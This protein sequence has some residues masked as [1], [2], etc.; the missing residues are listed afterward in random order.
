MN[1]QERPAAAKPQSNTVAPRQLPQHFEALRQGKA[2]FDLGRYAEAL[3]CFNLFETHNPGIAPLYQTRGLCLQRLGRFD[4]AQADFERSIALSP[5]EAETHKNLG[6]LHSRL[7]R[8]E[9]AFAS[10]DRALA[11]R[12]NFPAA[13]TEKARALWSLHRLDEAFAA[14]HKSL[15]LEPGNA[16]TIWNLAVLQMLTGDFERGLAGREARWKASLGLVDRGFSAPLWLGDQPIADKTILLHADEGLGDSIQL[17]RYAPMLAALGARVILEVSTPL[18][19]LLGGTTGV[20]ACIGRSS[21]PSLAFDL[22]C[23]LGSLPLA[24]TTRP[25]TIPFADG[26]LPAPAAER[27]AAWEDRLG[28]HD[29]F[30]VGLVWSG[31]PAHNNDHNRS[32]PLRTLAPLL[33]CDVQFVSLQKGARDQDRAFLDGHPDIVDL[34]E[35]L[36]DFSDTAALVACLDL[37]ISV[38]TSVAHLAGAM[39]APVWTMLPF[40]PDWRWL[41]GRDDSPWYSSMRLFRQP[42]R[43]DWVSVVDAVRRALDG[44]VCEWQSGAQQLQSKTP[45]AKPQ[46]AVISN[47]LGHMFRQRGRAD[48]AVLHFRRALELHP[49]DLDA[50]NCCGALLFNLGRYAE[51]LECFDVAEKLDPGSAALYQMRGACLQE[52]NRFEEAEADY[53]KSIALDPSQAETYNNFGLLHARLGRHEQA[54]AHFDRSLELRPDFSAVLNNKA[55]ALLNLQLLD[56]AVATFHRSLTVDPGNAPATFNL[57]TIQLLTGDLER[58]FAGREARW[59]LPVGLPERG[60]SQPLWR[61]DQPIAGKTLLLHSEE[62][63]G[64]A[65]Q[66]ARYA[67]M[68][69]A[70]GARVILE[71]Q[72]PIRQLL[73]EVSGVAD[74][75]D[76]PSATS[77]AFDLH[78]PLG[79]LPSAFGTRLDTIPFAESYIPAPPPERMAAWEDRLGP[80]DRFRVGLVWS[81]NPGHKNDHNRSMPLRT[82]APLLDCDVQFVS[83]QKSA[84]DEDLAFLRECSDIIDLSD[85]LT[86]MSDT[87]ALVACLDLVI[88]V[89]TSVAHLAGAL[90]APVWTMLPFNPDWRWLL[91]RDD[92]PWYSS[93]RLFRQPERGDWASVVDRVRS[94]L[95]GRVCEWRPGA[96]PLRRMAPI[97]GRQ[98]AVI[99]NH[100]GHM[101]WQ[102]QRTD[103][104]LRHFRRALEL[105]PSY[106]EAANSC[107]RLLFNL[108]RYAEA[109][110]CLDAAAQADPNSALLH[111]IRGD[112]LQ[113][114]G[115]F[116]D[117][118]AAYE[119]SLALDPGDADTHNKFGVLQVRLDRLDRALACFDRALELQPEFSGALSNKAL[120][121]LNL[122]LLDQAFATLRQSLTVD[123]DNAVA[124]YNLATLQLLT[125]DFAPGWLGR[126]ARW[127]LSVG[128]LHRGFSQAL[129]LGDQSIE[130]KTILLHADEGFGDAIQ[131]ARYVPMVAAL[132]ARVILE[133]QPPIRQLLA[134]VSG[135]AMCVDRPSASALPFDLHCPLGSLPLALGTQLDTIPSPEPYLPAPPAARVTAWDDRLGL[136]DCFR[137]GLVWSGNPAHKNDRD[138]S[139]PLDTLAPLLDCDVRF[140][141]LQKGPR[142]RDRAFLDQHPDIVDLTDQLTDFTD[143]AALMACL[144]LVISVDT[145]VAHLAGALG[146]PIWTLLP[147]NPDWRWLLNR[148]DSPWY[149]SMRLFRQPARNDWASVVDNVRHE[150]NGLVSARRSS[151]QPSLRLPAEA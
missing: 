76:R 27:V 133:V 28:P 43:D 62:G 48:E 141:S 4:E 8:M 57:A 120:V 142:D 44:R 149:R 2:L 117:A 35:D 80:H 15:A 135:V 97:T 108:G 113:E 134:D 98:Q 47:A 9:Q 36:A 5:L 131:F 24:C 116:D 105:H 18:Q 53:R 37:V 61:G 99:S 100:L 82:L 107:G 144:D 66:F 125:G 56:E 121:L 6:T 147:F 65:I 69:A 13:L 129:W 106:L 77:L 136:H 67:T 59:K 114:T 29:R 130:G 150:L 132:G 78:C 20:A 115:R 23:P 140:V 68:A 55:L 123:P 16:N 41:L 70:L 148:D 50:A 83:L 87:A 21:T 111:Q 92:S 139:I 91:G 110:E 10:F 40:N 151:Q 7:G 143:T 42:E 90:G 71:V 95:D 30:R 60:F 26:Y 86:D 38:D 88:S 101:F 137:V 19:Q 45:D 54:I 58:G 12:P 119:A 52:A 51:A 14:L 63:M 84:Q 74:C 17:A 79:T 81:G 3:D 22:H 34:T 104:A 127:R 138:R 64:D 39:G 126:E 109:L 72:P 103:E 32:M 46:Q 1:R 93:M 11:I 118:E 89:D 94:A 122:Q 102:R 124:T 75:V 96:H 85:D 146:A 73:A 128:L 145:S 25:D 31:N 112:C 33:D 49:H